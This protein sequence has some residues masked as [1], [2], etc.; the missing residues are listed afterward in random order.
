[1]S[2]LS[3]I[4]ADVE[5]RSKLFFWREMDPNLGRRRGGV[6]ELGR[7]SRARCDATV[8]GGPDEE[9]R[10][11]PE[12][13]FRHVEFLTIGLNVMTIHQIPRSTPENI[14]GFSVVRLLV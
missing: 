7:G 5:S 13:F 2:W 14:S 3:N 8:P 4:M 12:K 10:R 11:G 1:M 9:Q 6:F